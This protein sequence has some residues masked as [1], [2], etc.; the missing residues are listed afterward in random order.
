MN[1]EMWVTVLSIIVGGGAFAGIAGI[2]TALT[3]SKKGK[4]AMKNDDISMKSKDKD[5]IIQ[6]VER[7][8]DKHEARAERLENEVACLRG[9][10]LALVR[11][12]LV[13][14]QK[15]RDDPNAVIP[16]WPALSVYTQV[17]PG[18]AGV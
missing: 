11:N 13:L 6:M 17:G 18:T 9:D 2:I 4:H 5:D 15:M 16:P 7:I 8:S 1:T 12:V 3:G 10:V 14:E